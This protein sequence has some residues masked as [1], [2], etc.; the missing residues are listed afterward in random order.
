MGRVTDDLR[1][2]LIIVKTTKM[3]LALMNLFSFIIHGLTGQKVSGEYDLAQWP[4][5]DDDVLHGY[6]VDGIMCVVVCLGGPRTNLPRRRC[7]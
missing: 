3:K 1:G 5:H 6:E 2:D 7:C 4:L